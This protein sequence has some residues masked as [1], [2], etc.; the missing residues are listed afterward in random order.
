MVAEGDKADIGKKY[1]RN[2]FMC[3]KGAIFG[4]VE[5]FVAHKRVR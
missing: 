5:Y 3:S 1:I 2:D 4:K